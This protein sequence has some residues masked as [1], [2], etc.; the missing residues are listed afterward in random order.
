M[1]KHLSRV[2]SKNYLDILCLVLVAGGKE[3]ISLIHF[4]VV[5]C[6]IV[7]DLLWVSL[8]IE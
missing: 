4:E 1:V 8:E 2:S 3:G 5:K 6:E 7:T